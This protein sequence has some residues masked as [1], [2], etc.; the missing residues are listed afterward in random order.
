MMQ[1]LLNKVVAS[2]SDSKLA[3]ISGFYSFNAEQGSGWHKIGQVSCHGESCRSL[4]T[5]RRY[6]GQIG[7]PFCRYPF[8]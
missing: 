1:F 7:F 4:L 2:Q 8:D 6:V 3:T 5:P